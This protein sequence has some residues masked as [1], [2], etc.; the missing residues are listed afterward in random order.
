MTVYLGKDGKHVTPS[1]TATHANVTRLTA[2]IE[3]VGHKLYIG[4][5]FP[6]PASFD[7]LH[8]KT[9]HCCGTVRANR[10]WITKY[11]G[12]KMKMK[13]A[14]IKTKMKVA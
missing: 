12:H 4:N 14:D 1:M 11:F 8:T 10:K 2:R 3:H 13:S 5:F 7:D 9:I 6:S